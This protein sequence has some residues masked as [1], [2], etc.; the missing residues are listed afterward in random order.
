MT[1]HYLTK[2]EYIDLFNKGTIPKGYELVNQI[3][4]NEVEI[5]ILKRSN[6]FFLTLL[7]NAKYEVSEEFIEYEDE[8]WIDIM[9][10][11]NV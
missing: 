11:L 6:K 5:F 3:Y 8:D 2:N 9:V 10:E 1:A 7:Q 4:E